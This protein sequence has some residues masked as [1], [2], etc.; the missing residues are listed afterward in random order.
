LEDEAI[1]MTENE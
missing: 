1:F